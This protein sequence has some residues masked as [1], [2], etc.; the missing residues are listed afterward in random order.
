MLL[1]PQTQQFPSGRT[2]RGPRPSNM[3]N[4][5]DMGPAPGT[6]PGAPVF[7]NQKAAAAGGQS[8]PAGFSP[9]QQGVLTRLLVRRWL[10]LLFLAIMLALMV[11]HKLPWQAALA[12]SIAFSCGAAVIPRSGLPAF[13]RP[14]ARRDEALPL[15]I[16][17]SLVEALPEPAILLSGDGTVLSFNGEARG[18]L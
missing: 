10:I 4:S 12:A 8:A 5:F 6:L 7:D 3:L 2:V 17:K 18:L 15:E 11:F 16:A 13:P 9:S 14:A 1:Y